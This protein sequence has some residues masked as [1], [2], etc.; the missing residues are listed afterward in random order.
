MKYLKT[1]EY[2]YVYIHNSSGYIRERS[3]IPPGEREN[4][5]Q[6]CLYGGICQFPGG[7]DSMWWFQ[8]LGIFTR[9]RGG[10]DY[11][12]TCAYLSNGFVKNHQNPYRIHQSYS[13]SW[14]NVPLLNSSSWIIV[15]YPDSSQSSGNFPFS[16]WT[17]AVRERQTKKPESD[18]LPKTWTLGFSF[19]GKEDMSATEGFGK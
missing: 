13:T 6:K 8:I 1:D 4:H 5:L 14:M 19:A 9:I 7:Y 12:L 15:V 18:K 3:H 10:Y 2:V 16:G 11:N 17:L